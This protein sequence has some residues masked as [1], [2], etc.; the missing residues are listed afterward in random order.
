[1]QVL[2]EARANVSELLEPVD[3]FGLEFALSI[4]DT[5]VNFQAVLVGE[6]LPD[7]VIKFQKWAD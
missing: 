2:A 6:K 7:S 3:F 1:M 5:H 4:D